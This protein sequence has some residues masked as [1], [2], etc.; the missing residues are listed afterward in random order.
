MM[1]AERFARIKKAFERNGG[2]IDQ[3]EEAQRLLKYHGAEAATFNAKTIVLKPNPSNAE[4]FE[5]FIHTA[6]YRTGRATGANIVEME[7]EAAQKLLRFADR[8]GL[9]IEEQ[10][11]IR[12]RLNHLLMIY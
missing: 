11:A 8:Y 3:S 5:E 9:K 2:I 12:N 4:V 1:N 10:E 7:I 6:Q